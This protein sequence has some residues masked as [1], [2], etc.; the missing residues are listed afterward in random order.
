MVYLVFQF[1]KKWKT[2]KT[3][4]KCKRV[5]LKRYFQNVGM[6]RVIFNLLN[7]IRYHPFWIQYLYPKSQYKCDSRQWNWKTGLSLARPLSIFAFI[8]LYF[9]LYLRFHKRCS[10]YKNIGYYCVIKIL[11]CSLFVIIIIIF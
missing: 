1:P 3:A 5:W 6:N 11:C 8:R 9:L 2:T 10:V 7:V 4:G